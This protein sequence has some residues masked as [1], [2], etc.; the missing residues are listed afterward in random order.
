MYDGQ[1]TIEVASSVGRLVL[2]RQVLMQPESGRHVVPGDT[3][4]PAHGGMII[5]RGLQERACLRAD[6]LP[7]ATA[8]HLLGWQMQEEGLCARTLRTVVR[9]PGSPRARAEQAEVRAL[10]GR[11]Y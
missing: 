5:T 10:A 4:L 1:A 3:L 7:F 2:R 11:V 8:T 6:T 9:V